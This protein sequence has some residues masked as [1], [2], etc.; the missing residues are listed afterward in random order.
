MITARGWLAP[1]PKLV[2]ALAVTSGAQQLLSF[3]LLGAQ[4]VPEA[5]D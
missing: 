4:S 1:D 2:G 5:E 3:E